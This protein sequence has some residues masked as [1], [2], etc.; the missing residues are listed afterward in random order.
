MHFHR[1]V[2]ACSF[3]LALP[4]SPV[5]AWSEAGHRIIASIAFRQLTP[6]AQST[7][8]AILTHHPR[9]AEDFARYMPP[10]V[11]AGDESSRNEWLFQQAAIW[12]DMARGLP[13]ELKR[14]YNHPTWH[15][16]DIPSFLSDDDRAALEK[17]LAINMSLEAPESAQPE[18]NAVQAI[19]LAR[20]SLS[21]RAD[22]AGEAAV[23]LCWL[24][25]D[26]GDLHQPL[27]STAIFAVKLFP[28][29]DKGG[30]SVL[31]QQGFNL[32][33]LWDEFLGDW[34]TF[35]MARDRAMELAGRED[36]ATV[37]REAAAQLDEKVWLDESRHLAQSIVYSPEVLSYL[38]VQATRTD[39]QP[40]SPLRLSE[41]YLTG[42]VRIATNRVTQAGFRL[43][44]VL[45]ETGTRRE[46][47][48]K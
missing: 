22:D 28:E 12:P 18:M 9:Y 27:H 25:H 36:L 24:L 33:A 30:N 29:G 5:Q 40:P 13:D 23:W 38:R 21:T 37:G 3:L 48:K 19:R 34:A 46:E 35:A 47:N 15:Y 44:A 31:T 17:T 20:R 11:A 41:E 7:W 39:G 6:T 10:D 1:F 8:A 42:G 32:H 16:I 4:C 43:G 45:Q 14:I 2:V 26:L